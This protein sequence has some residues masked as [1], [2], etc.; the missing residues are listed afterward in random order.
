M[1]RFV[2]TKYKYGMKPHVWTA[3]AVT[4]VSPKGGHDNRHTRHFETPGAAKAYLD[5]IGGFIVDPDWSELPGTRIPGR[6]LN[7]R[8][9][10]EPAQLTLGVA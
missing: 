8:K 5:S 4:P 3:F 6:R 9:R 2:L 7:A 1:K 10:R